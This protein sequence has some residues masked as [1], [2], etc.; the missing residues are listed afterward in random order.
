LL[1]AAS[2]AQPLPA[3]AEFCNNGPAIH[4]F[5]KGARLRLQVQKCCGLNLKHNLPFLDGPLD[6]HAFFH[7]AA[8]DRLKCIKADVTAIFHKSTYRFIS[9]LLFQT[10]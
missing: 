7:G 1:R 10:R 9:F 2:G 8:A 4:A 5:C 3:L 6:R